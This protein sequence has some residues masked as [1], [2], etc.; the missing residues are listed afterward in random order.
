MK[1]TR[2]R[3]LTF[4]LFF[5]STQGLFAQFITLS[6]VLLDGSTKDTLY[7]SNVYIK[8]TPYGCST[9]STGKFLLKFPK[10][11][12]TITC[13]SMGYTTVHIL[14]DT[15]TVFQNLS[16]EME[17][18]TQVPSV[19]ITYRENPAYRII[20]NCNDHK[21]QYNKENIPQYKYRSYNQ[22]GIYIT[23]IA[24]SIR[25]TKLWKE[26]GSVLDSVNLQ[27]PFTGQPMLPVLYS[28]T[29]SQVL[30]RS[31]P[32][33]KKEII[34]GVKVRGVGMEDGS[35]LSQVLG[36]TFQDYNFYSNYVTVLNKDFASPIGDAWRLQYN[37]TLVDSGF[38]NGRYGYKI[39]YEP[40]RKQDLCFTG[41]L[42]IED[43]TFALYYITASISR[44][45]NLNYVDSL[46]FIQI[47]QNYTGLGWLPYR[48]SIEVDLQN[49]TKRTPSIA[50]TYSCTLLEAEIDSVQADRYY[51]PAIEVL[52]D[53]SSRDA[54]YWSSVVPMNY[55][56]SKQN[57]YQWIDTLRD[58]PTVKTYIELVDIAVT[59]YKTIGKIELGPYLFAYS[60]NFTERHRFQIGCK[61]N[62]HFSKHWELKGYLA[63]GTG[64][65]RIKYK[66]G[67]RYIFQRKRWSEAE[68]FYWND[69][70]QVSAPASELS[71]NFIFLAATRWLTL[72]GPYYKSQWNVQWYKH[73]HPLAQIT[74]G[75][76]T[77]DFNP[78]YP[79]GYVAS[80]GSIQDFYSTTET[81]V[82]W[83]ISFDEK[84]L[85]NGNN[86]ISLGDKRYPII[87]LN[88]TYG[89]QWL[90]GYFEYH[91]ASLRID[92]TFKVGILGRTTYRYEIGKIFQPLPYP[93]LEVHIGNETPFY[94]T[95]AFNLMNFFEFVS[96]QYTSIRFQH[97]FEGLLFNRMPI[98]RR[99]KWRFF[100]T[101]NVLWGSLSTANRQGIAP[102]TPTGEPAYAIAALDSGLPYAEVG[103]GI[104]NIFKLL[105]VDFVHRLTYRNQPDISTFGVK[106]SLHLTL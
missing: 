92:H 53:A 98:V 91:K 43:S 29:V 63:Y 51:Q 42:Y 84:V 15:L 17:L 34:E 106:V 11:L 6:G 61:T 46:Y 32:S 39:L 12:D 81:Y 77:I 50:A 95:A 56:T 67:V 10:T 89:N 87:A 45:A 104:D 36:N 76:R 72:R 55:D 105:R 8:G 79:M 85:I 28:E 65:N 24:D 71:E 103:Y 7:F 4:L 3:Y 101:S 41:E 93:L 20:R 27:H 99:F 74:I 86:R 48:T 31:H 62:D 5:F 38:Y 13:Q 64:D 58:L 44:T 40:K 57:A 1:S 25:D 80:N 30:S 16:I 94:T 100:I 102:L 35:L 96:D 23:D 97:D 78:I 60:Y 19:I 90:K 59:G 18:D 9:G 14:V 33:S 73:W 2:V 26:I 47:M 54:V 82:Q 69:I 49:L 37:Y 75:L 22:T 83:R 21:A 52:E 66:V 88:Y 68:L 70:D